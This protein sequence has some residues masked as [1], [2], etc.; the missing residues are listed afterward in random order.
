M[1]R[2]HVI[3]NYFLYPTGHH[4]ASWRH[5]QAQPHRLIDVTYYIEMAKRAEA[6]LFDAIFLA[7]APHLGQPRYKPDGGL[8]PITLL[9]ALATHTRHLGFIATASTTFYEPFNLARLFASLDHISG[10]RA[11]WN[12]VTTED[13]GRV[14]ENF[15]PDPHP[16]AAERYARADEFIRIVNGLWDTWE[17]GAVLADKAGGVF[18]DPARIHRTRFEGRYFR[19]DAALNVQ[20]SAQG[21][22]VLV[23][24]G[25]SDA[26]RQLAARHAEVIFTGHQT[27]EDA[28]AFY[29]DVK[30]RAQ[31]HFGRNPEDIKILPGLSPFVGETEAEALRNQRELD[32]LT[33]VQFGLNQLRGYLG[34]DLD[35]LDIDRPIP[36]D[37]QPDWG[38]VLRNAKGRKQLVGGIIQRENP[39]IRSLLYRLATARGHFS[40]AG[41]AEQVAD[42][43]ENWFNGRAADGFNIM[44][45]SYPQSFGLFTERVIPLLQQRG[46]FRTEYAGR[47]L[48]D[49]YGLARPAGRGARDELVA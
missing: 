44:P 14:A 31:E 42:L 38:E 18:A 16:S 48:R 9:T 40:F 34:I 21:R 23:Q 7:D 10:G 1:S 2:K 30:T 47:T 36:A 43:I 8:E 20:R 39:T 5:P 35:G 11:G 17:D 6:S 15:G 25:A 28:Q 37:L 49:N 4:E 41:T 29:R 46:L 45:P 32:E 26:G 22:P 27:V 3:L 13:Y 33:H 12:A 24:A 19:V